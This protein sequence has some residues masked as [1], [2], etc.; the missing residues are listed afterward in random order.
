MNLSK[1]ITQGE[2]ETTEFKQSFDKDVIETVGAFANKKGGNILIGVT[3]KGEIKGIT[4]GKESLK[5]WTIKFPKQLIL[6]L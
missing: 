1:L 3:D 6:K 5:E 2:N 4:I